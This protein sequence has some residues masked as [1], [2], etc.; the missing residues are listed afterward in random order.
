MARLADMSRRL[1]RVT[2]PEHRVHRWAVPA[3][4]REVGGT[5]EADAAHRAVTWVHVEVGVPP[6]RSLMAQSLALVSV[7]EI[8]VPI[9][10]GAAA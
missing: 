5:S 4:V 9:H 6:L 7:E 2:I 3:T 1:W 10:K 8:T